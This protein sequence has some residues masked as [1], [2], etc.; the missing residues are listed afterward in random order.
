MTVR[1]NDTPV[2]I[3]AVSNS[4]TCC[5]AW[6]IGDSIVEVGQIY[7]VIEIET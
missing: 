5:Y 6:F 4:S 7:K 1:I 3:M 2:L